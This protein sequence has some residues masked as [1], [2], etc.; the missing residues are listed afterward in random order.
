M[1]LS[2]GGQESHDGQQQERGVEAVGL[3]VLAEHAPLGDA[4]VQDLG[5]D[6]VGA[7]LPPLGAFVVAAFLGEVGAARGRDP[8]HHLGGGEVLGVAADLPDALVG[9]VP[10]VQ[11]RVHETGEAVPHRR[12]DRARAPVELDVQRVEDHPPD[13]VLLLVPGA[14]PDPDRARPAIAGQVVEGLLGQVAFPADAVHDLQLELAVEVTPADRVEDEAPV[15]DRFPVEAQPV[16]RA[17]HER[18]VPDPGE[19][20]VP[21]A[22][23]APGL[24]Q[25]GR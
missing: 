2:V 25:R 21:V 1:R 11:G 13:V 19:A 18:R 7:G 8:A 12:H 20:V 14:V 17:E 9:L 4:L 10:V 23:P 22:G 3:V 24:R 15:L 16:Q 6:L 5:L